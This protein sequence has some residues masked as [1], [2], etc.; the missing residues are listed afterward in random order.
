LERALSHGKVYIISNA[1]YTWIRKC[2]K[3]FYPKLYEVALKQE[4]LPLEIVSARDLFGTE[5]PASPLKWKVY[6]SL[7]NRSKLS[8][9]L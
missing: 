5:L 3:S 1:A 9:K 2:L 8:L 7:T 6:L 4:S